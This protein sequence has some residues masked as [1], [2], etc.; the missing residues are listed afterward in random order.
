MFGVILLIVGILLRIS[1]NARF[2]RFRNLRSVIL[3]N[4]PKIVDQVSFS[5]SNH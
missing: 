3:V 2:F 5:K 4:N 1:F